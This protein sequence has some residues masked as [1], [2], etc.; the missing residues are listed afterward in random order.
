MYIYERVLSTE[1]EARISMQRWE[2]SWYIHG[3]ARWL[4]CVQQSE[5]GIAEDI[6]RSGSQIIEDFERSLFFNFSE[7]GKQRILSRGLV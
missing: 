5:Q 4:K 7:T 6:R 1:E 3:R 2:Y